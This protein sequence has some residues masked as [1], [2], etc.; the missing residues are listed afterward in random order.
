MKLIE[1]CLKHPLFFSLFWLCVVFYGLYSFYKMPIEYVPRNKFLTL[2]IDTKY[3]NAG[4]EK[5]LDDVTKILEEVLLQNVDGIENLYSI[6]RNEESEIKLEFK[7][8]VSF[9]EAKADV[10]FAVT[11]A[12]PRLPNEIK[13]PQIAENGPYRFPLFTVAAHSNL[14]SPEFYDYIKNQIQPRFLQVPGIARVEI[15]GQRQKQATIL[16]DLNKLKEMEISPNDVADRL[17]N[18]GANLHFKSD[19]AYK[20]AGEFLTLDEIKRIPLH[21]LSKGKEIPIKDI[22]EVK[23]ELSEPSA[24]TYLNGK[25]CLLLEVYSHKD[26]NEYQLEKT[27]PLFLESL[28]KNTQQHELSFSLLGNRKPNTVSMIDDF[29]INIS[30]AI[31]MALLII[32]YV[33]RDFRSILISSS[34]IPV[35]ICG[36]FIILNLLDMSFNIYIVMGTLISIGLIIDD[37]IVI[38]ENIFRHIEMGLSPM[39]ATLT[40]MKEM[41]APVIATTLVMIGVCLPYLLVENTRATQHY[42]DFM[43]ATIIALSVSLFEAVTLGPILC[44]YLLK[45]QEIAKKNISFLNIFTKLSDK[46]SN[47]SY[48]IVFSALCFFVLGVLIQSRVPSL[49]DY[50]I[51]IGVIEIHQTPYQD[52]TLEQLNQKAL[53]FATNLQNQYPD[54]ATLGL[55]VGKD[56]NV[57]YLDMVPKNKR[58][59]TVEQFTADLYKILDN[60]VQNKKIHKYYISNNVEP[61]SD[62]VPTYGLQLI[63]INPV[64][65]KSYSEKLF[66]LLQKSNSIVSLKNSATEIDNEMNISLKYPQ[67]GYLGVGTSFISKEMDILINGCE[68]QNTRYKP[69]KGD[70]IKPE[71]MVKNAYSYHNISNASKLGYVPNLK[72]MLIPFE[73][74][75]ATNEQSVSPIEMNRKNGIDM[76]KIT[77]DVYPADKINPIAF[78]TKAI[79]D[80]IPL[81]KQVELNWDGSLKDSKEFDSVSKKTMT[82]SLVFILIILMV[83]YK[84]VI[85]SWS[86]LLAI[87]LVNFGAILVLYMMNCPIYNFST[88][89]IHLAMGIAAKNGIV[90]VSYALYLIAAGTPPKYAANEAA[91]L[92]ARPIL[93]TSVGVLLAILPVFIEWNNYSRLQ[94]GLGYAVVGGVLLS[95]CASLLVMPIFFRWLYPAHL[96]VNQWIEK[97][98]AIFHG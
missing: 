94:F 83:L 16:L 57:F 75:A 70:V 26:A 12:V 8:G 31:L 38:R 11:Q 14:E 32:W 84:S 63:G 47:H 35:S 58:H 50:R 55:K 96:K 27:F 77:G 43:I 86:I 54:I 3:P 71:I 65:L 40:G 61:I 19:I 17:K 88:L 78:T 79:T 49:G 2:T 22:A 74:L 13:F 59:E 87:P 18:Y 56:E 62:Y 90:L 68:L 81:P 46:C 80:E 73:H 89:G 53:H 29:K 34:S 39:D 28:Q 52:M 76:V 44:A 66:S 24:Y 30:I 82:L 25:P 85:L 67:M 93:M 6:S 42:E 37:I 5:V 48:I 51:P 36:C 97:L 20:I 4:K 91:K 1:F 15:F 64:E 7:Y 10:F 72:N 60:D 98:A 9:A 45:K 95:I 92:R 23:L 69:F 21:F 33:F 41:L